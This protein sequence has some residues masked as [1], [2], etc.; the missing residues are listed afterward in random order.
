LASE[1]ALLFSPAC[2]AQEVNPDHFTNTGV[3]DVYEAAPGKV[4]APKVKQ[5]LLTLQSRTR[6][7]NLPATLQLAAKRSSSFSA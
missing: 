6:Q 4:T 1:P 3:Q 2:K 7:I 5:K